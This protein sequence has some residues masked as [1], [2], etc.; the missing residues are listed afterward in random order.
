[1]QASEELCA[2]RKFMVGCYHRGRIKIFAGG[3]QT[4][5]DCDKIRCSLTEAHIN[6]SE[7]LA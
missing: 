7:E 6:H 1:L 3:T 2:Y 5:F 4:K